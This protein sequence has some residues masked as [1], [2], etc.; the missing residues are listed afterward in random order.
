MLPTLDEIHIFKE[1]ASLYNPFCPWLCLSQCLSLCLCNKFWGLWLV[2]NANVKSSWRLLRW[3]SST[4][5]TYLLQ[6]ENITNEERLSW[7][8]PHSDLKNKDDSACGE[9]Y[10][11]LEKWRSKV[12][13]FERDKGCLCIPT[14]LAST[15]VHTDLQPLGIQRQMLS[16]QMTILY[17][18]LWV[19]GWLAGSVII[20]PLRGSIL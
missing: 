18:S 16:F 2:K 17:C 12:L 4:K 7:A 5:A 13:S 19:G 15:N 20:V 10:S 3:M 6:Q 11:L 14:I 1:A 9:M 8:M